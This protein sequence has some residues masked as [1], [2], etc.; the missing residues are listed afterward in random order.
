[1]HDQAI[2]PLNVLQDMKKLLVVKL[3]N[4]SNFIL[5]DLKTFL[6]TLHQFMMSLNHFRKLI[7]TMFQQVKKMRKMSLS[8]LFQVSLKK[9]KKILL[10]GFLPHLQFRGAGFAA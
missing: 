6:M 8:A 10:L 9:N 2:I 3:K 5:M 1:M 7:V 4:Q